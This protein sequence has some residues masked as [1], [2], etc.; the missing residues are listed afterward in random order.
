ME[1]LT[2]EEEATLTAMI[3]SVKGHH[4][5]VRLNDD[6]APCVRAEDVEFAH[7]GVPCPANVAW[8][9]DG[10]D[11][12]GG[13]RGELLSDIIS[14]ADGCVVDARTAYIRSRLL[15]LIPEAK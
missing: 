6:D 9:K 1:L 14:A 5:V 12:E 2:V 15:T 13:P 4:W 11:W 7:I 8:H 3:E 10:A